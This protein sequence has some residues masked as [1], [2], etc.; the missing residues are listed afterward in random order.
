MGVMGVM[1]LPRRFFSRKEAKKQQ[2]AQSRAFPF[3]DRF[4]QEFLFAFCYT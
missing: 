2:M 4:E 1:G 3:F